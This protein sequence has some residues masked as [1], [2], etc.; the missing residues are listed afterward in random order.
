MTSQTFLDLSTMLLK[1]KW[2]LNYDEHEVQD[3]MEQYYGREYDIDEVR[4]A[5]GIIADNLANVFN[6]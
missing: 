1:E 5:I 2:N 4:K 6:V 3:T